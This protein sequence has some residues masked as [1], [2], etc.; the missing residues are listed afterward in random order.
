LKIYHIVSLS[1]IIY[2]TLLSNSCLGDD[3]SLSFSL[4]PTIQELSVKPGDKRIVNINILNSIN[5]NLALI[6]DAFPFVP[7]DNQGNIELRNKDKIMDSWI[8]LYDINL[9][10]DLY[11]KES[12]KKQFPFIISIPKNAKEGDY[13][14]AFVF[15]GKKDISDSVN[16]APLIINQEVQI[17]SLLLISVENKPLSKKLSLIN[18]STPLI[19]TKSPLVF[20]I[21][22]KNS[23]RT[24]IKT[25]GKIEIKNILSGK[26]VSNIVIPSHTVL[27]DYTRSL[28][29][30]TSPLVWNPTKSIGIY[31]ATVL[32]DNE[33]D[34]K[35]LLSKSKC[36]IALP[37][38]IFLIFIIPIFIILRKIIKK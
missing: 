28:K 10:Q 25:R 24:K 30:Y 2:L 4:N 17:A 35:N 13:Y 9:P 16:N 8:A 14:I 21:D 7:Q 32:L 38:E 11:L 3:S 26:I 29:N 37:Q 27:S 5:Q 19:F 23:G 31:Q 12:E 36:F 34:S 33:D 1:I 18:F 6:V 15:S 22:I 20:E